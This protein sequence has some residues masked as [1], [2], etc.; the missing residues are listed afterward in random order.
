MRTVRYF[1][2]YATAMSTYG[3][4][5]IAIVGVFVLLT[6]WLTGRLH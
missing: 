4:V 1:A 6:L 2:R 5:V 3:T